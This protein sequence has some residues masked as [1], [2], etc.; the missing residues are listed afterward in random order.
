MHVADPGGLERPAA[1][2]APRAAESGPQRFSPSG[3]AQT[4]QAEQASPDPVTHGRYIVEN[5]AMCWRCHTPVDQDGNPDV[6]RWLMGSPVILEPTR[7]VTDWAT[8]APRLAGDPP[9]TDEEFVRLLMTG[10]SRRGTYLRPPMPEFRMTR[11][12]AG[13][14][15]AYLKSLG[16]ERDIDARGQDP[17][18]RLPVIRMVEARGGGV[19]NG[20]RPGFPSGTACSSILRQHTSKGRV[21]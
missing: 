5:V 7:D 18:D 10:I 20:P 21:R 17:P 1:T 12:D 13:A 11:A 16:V 6:T 8:V 4:A 3:A 9:G 15:L 14:V 2:L 19:T